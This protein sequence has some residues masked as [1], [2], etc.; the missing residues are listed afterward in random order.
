MNP[1]NSIKGTIGAG[2]V[3]AAATGVATMGPAF[4]FPSFIVWLHV[5][6]GVTWLGLLYYFAFVQTP[7]L[8]EAAA[9]VGGPGGAGIT[10]YVAPRAS[11][12]FRW[13]SVFTWLTGAAYLGHL[14]ILPDAFAL[15]FLAH[16]L[17]DRIIGI[18]AWLGTIMLINVWVL[19]WPNQKKLLGLVEAGA[20]EILRAR[21]I[22]FVTSRANA[23]L[24]VP[25]IM[26]MV[27]YGHGGFFL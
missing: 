27:G 24:S 2:V 6:G 4:N 14:R 12:W 18:G 17:P 25:L 1:L 16:S 11:A 22:V 9:D 20:A 8:Q 3:A 21:R 15:G 7:A 23:V 10:K 13:A 5:L 26:S 19:I